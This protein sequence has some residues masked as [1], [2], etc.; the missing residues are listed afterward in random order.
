MQRYDKYKDSSVKWLGEI[1]R[2]GIRSAVIPYGNQAE[3]EDCGEVL[4]IIKNIILL[5]RCFA[6]WLSVFFFSASE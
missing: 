2:Q 3:L 1:P 6:F 5:C 4:K